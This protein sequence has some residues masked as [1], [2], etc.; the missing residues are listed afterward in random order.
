MIRIC[1]QIVYSDKE[2]WEN[3]LVK[4]IKSKEKLIKI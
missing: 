3:K 2:D 1:Q 4:A